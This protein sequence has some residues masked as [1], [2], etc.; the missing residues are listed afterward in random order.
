LRPLDLGHRLGGALGNGR[1]VFRFGHQNLGRRMGK[2]KPE[3]ETRT[4]PGDPDA[5][6]KRKPRKA[7]RASAAMAENRIPSAAQP[8][9]YHNPAAYPPPV[10]SHC[11]GGNPKAAPRP[12]CGGVTPYS[13]QVCSKERPSARAAFPAVPPGAPVARNR[14]RAP[15][16]RGSRAPVSVLT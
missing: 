3:V 16:P 12:E 10:R 9:P 7:M 14:L 15:F 4:P 2:E 1:F 5:K 8:G 11:G 13:G 6:G